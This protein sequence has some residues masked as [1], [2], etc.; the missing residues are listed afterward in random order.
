MTKKM[1]YQFFFAIVALGVCLQPLIDVNLTNQQAI[2][3]AWLLFLTFI[4]YFICLYIYG[5]RTFVSKKKIET[6]DFC[7]SFVTLLLLILNIT[8]VNSSLQLLNLISVLKGIRFMGFI[9]KLHPYNV[10][11]QIIYNLFPFIFEVL[12]ILFVVFFIFT[13]LGIYIWGGKVTLNTPNDSKW[14]QFYP[15]YYEFLN[16]NDFYGGMLTLFAVLIVNN[17]IDVV[18]VFT[19][20]IDYN[21][22][23]RFFFALFYLI[24]N[25]LSLY[26]L[27]GLV[28]DVAVTNLAEDIGKTSFIFSP[29][30]P[31]VTMFLF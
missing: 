25:L 29:K 7:C 3:T 27:I 2:V 21:T 13:T 5:I 10:L 15:T 9:L 12:M 31:M 23:W 6:F 14:P 18:S 8:G 1:L 16:F 17:W 11:S 4:D 24:G 30:M 28:I 22:Q 26:I 20:F 19:D